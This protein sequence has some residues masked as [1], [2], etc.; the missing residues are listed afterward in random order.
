MPGIDFRQVRALISLSDVL[1]LLEYVPVSSWGHQV[2]GPCPIH[3]SAF[4]RSRCFSAHLQRNMF[5][6]FKCGASGNQLDLYAAVRGLSV[7]EA[8]L[9]LC[10][11]LHKDIPWI[12]R[13]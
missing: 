6:C 7:F 13:W 5:H 9:S 8:A 3:R 12:D 4:A 1:A 11:R 10:A 2:R